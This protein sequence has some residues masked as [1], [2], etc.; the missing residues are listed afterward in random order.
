MGLRLISNH[1]PYKNAFLEKIGS[2]V[3]YI[4]MSQTDLSVLKYIMMAEINDLVQHNKD[5]I[6]IKFCTVL[7]IM[8]HT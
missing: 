4:V 7:S 5:L 2:V 6:L 1:K 8:Y 3:Q